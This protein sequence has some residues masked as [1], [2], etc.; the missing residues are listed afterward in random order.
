MGTITFALL[1]M[2]ISSGHMQCPAA[3]TVSRCPSAIFLLAWMECHSWSAP[4]L[5]DVAL[6]KLQCLLCEL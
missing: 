1:E 6:S 5:Q 3:C 2:H 4:V